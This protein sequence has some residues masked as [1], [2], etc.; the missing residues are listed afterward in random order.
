MAPEKKKIKHSVSPGV[1][2]TVIMDHAFCINTCR[3]TIHL[4]RKHPKLGKNF[5]FLFLMLVILFASSSSISSMHRP[6]AEE[7]LLVEEEAKLQRYPSI[8]MMAHH[9]L[10]QAREEADHIK[11]KMRQATLEEAKKINQRAFKEAV[12]D[13]M[14]IKD[15]TVFLDLITK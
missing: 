8:I 11:Q 12:R 6:A 14:R 3:P 4:R 13:G 2:T 7:V 1:A 9:I 5:L 15:S 10:L